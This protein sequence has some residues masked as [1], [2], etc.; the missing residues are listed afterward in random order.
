VRRFASDFVGTTISESVRPNLCAAA[1]R[2]NVDTRTGS[3]A[4][5]GIQL[6]IGTLV[7]NTA[8][9]L[10]VGDRSKVGQLRRD[11]PR[12][13]GVRRQICQRLLYDGDHSDLSTAEF[14]PT[15]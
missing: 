5:S 11:R 12:G 6:Q 7:T 14:S 13:C 2:R 10:H 8:L 15:P 1:K 9:P 4:V 3:D